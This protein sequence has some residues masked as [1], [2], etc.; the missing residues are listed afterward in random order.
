MKPKKMTLFPRIAAYLEALPLP[1]SSR[2]AQLIEIS[3]YIHQRWRAR[4]EVRLVFICTHN[5]RRSVFAQ[6]WLTVLSDYYGYRGITAY[7]GGAEVTAVHPNTLAAM[8]RAG[9]L[10]SGSEGANPEY[11]LRYADSSEP[12]VCFS[13]AFD[14]PDNPS[15][16]F[17]AVMVCSEAEEA[18]PY[19]PGVDRRFLLTFDDPG[20]A[21]GTPHE[22]EAYD[23]ACR[24]IGAEMKFIIMNIP[25]NG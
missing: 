19:V 7:S 13:K 11:V 15:Q 6:V 24:I 17:A 4:E 25:S 5:S 12:L 16:G 2:Q 23:K 1:S 21:D 3:K 8:E 10:I 22:Q 20:H 9:F 14:H 18:C